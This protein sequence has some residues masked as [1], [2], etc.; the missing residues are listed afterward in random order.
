[1]PRITRTPSVSSNSSSSSESAGGESANFSDWASSLHG[2]RRTKSLFDDNLLDSP[3]DAVAYD[4]RVHQ[5]NLDQVLAGLSLKDDYARIRLVNFIRK[6]VS[7]SVK[8]PQ[9]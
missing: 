8:R 3:E 1:M 9:P 5:F 2:A 7:C 4:A 6:E